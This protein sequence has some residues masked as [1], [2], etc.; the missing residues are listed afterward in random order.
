M[1]IL[2]APPQ[3]RVCLVYS[4]MFENVLPICR[5]LSRPDRLTRDSGRHKKIWGVSGDAWL[6]FIQGWDD[7]RMRKPYVALTLHTTKCTEGRQG[8]NIWYNKAWFCTC[9]PFLKVMGILLL[10]VAWT[11]GWGTLTD[12]LSPTAYIREHSESKNYWKIKGQ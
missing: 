1:F 10:L 7:P 11:S 5:S 6:A 12:S 9:E 4:E 8:A 2:D 3:K